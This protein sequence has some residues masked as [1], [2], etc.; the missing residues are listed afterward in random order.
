LAANIYGMK[1][2]LISGKH[3][4]EDNFSGTLCYYFEVK[5]LWKEGHNWWVADLWAKE[6]QNSHFSIF[7]VGF[8]LST[9]DIG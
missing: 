5:Q 1:G 8:G 3:F 7:E 4:R 9:I 2:F 6:L